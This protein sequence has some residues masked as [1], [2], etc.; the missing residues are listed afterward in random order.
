MKLIETTNAD[1]NAVEVQG[2][3]DEKDKALKEVISIWGI[4]PKGVTELKKRVLE[5]NVVNITRSRK[6]YK[7]SFLE[8]GS[9]W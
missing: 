2:I 7:P 9:S 3:W 1:I 6:H 8:K 5:D 4:L